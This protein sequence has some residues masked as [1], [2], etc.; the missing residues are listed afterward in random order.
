MREDSNRF[1]ITAQ[2]LGSQRMANGPA[3]TSGESAHL[4]LQRGGSDGTTGPLRRSEQRENLFANFNSATLTCGRFKTLLSYSNLISHP[5][6]IKESS[7]EETAA[8]SYFLFQPSH[9]S[10]QG[11][12]DSKLFFPFFSFY[13]HISSY[14][15]ISYLSPLQRLEVR[16][17]LLAISVHLL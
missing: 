6:L 7:G 17:N 1:L 13:I 4:E 9:H 2:T 8:C 3:P 5:W 14:H 11:I 10:M 12:Q 16:E 15:I